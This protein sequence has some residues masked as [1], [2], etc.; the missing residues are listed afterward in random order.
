MRRGR[1]TTWNTNNYARP[2]LRALWGIVRET[3]IIVGGAALMGAV[4]WG[5]SALAILMW[6]E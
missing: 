2:R 4:V 3:V 5:G 1:Y 6:G